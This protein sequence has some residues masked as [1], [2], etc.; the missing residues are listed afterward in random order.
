MGGG[1]IWLRVMSQGSFN[2]SSDEPFASA[3]RD[4]VNRS[5]KQLVINANIGVKPICFE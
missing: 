3:T 5:F 4:L 2:I 1:N